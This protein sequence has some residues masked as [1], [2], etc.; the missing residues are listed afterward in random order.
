MDRDRR[1][2][3]STADKVFAQTTSD[4]FL[5]R[6]TRRAARAA[7]GQRANNKMVVLGLVKVRLEWTARPAHRRIN[8][9]AAQKPP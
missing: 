9:A 8:E 1:L 7:A 3:F 5:L 6:T 2:R 4:V